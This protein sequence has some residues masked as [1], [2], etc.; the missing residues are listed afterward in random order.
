MIKL[1]LTIKRILNRMALPNFRLCYSFILLSFLNFFQGSILFLS[2]D[3]VMG[4][5]F[6]LNAICF[7]VIYFST[8]PDFS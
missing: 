3:P 8:N 5:L 2:G 6:W 4:A 1:Y 7:M